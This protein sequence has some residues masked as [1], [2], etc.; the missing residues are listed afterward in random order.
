MPTL[1]LGAYAIC[2]EDDRIL[3]ARL[4]DDDRT[5]P[6]YWT[7]PG[8]GVEF[9]ES[10][11]DAVLRELTEETGLRGRIRGIL[12]VFS[13]HHACTSDRPRPE[14]H[15]V[16]ILYRVDTEPGDL[17]PEAEGSTDTCAWIALSAAAELPLVDL[18]RHAVS[19]L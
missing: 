9:G 11:D 1:Y 14:A 5:H 7:L 15:V 19:L 17:V 12:G 8:G 18:A 10:P 4:R 2:V 16:G 6:G 3:L 13:R